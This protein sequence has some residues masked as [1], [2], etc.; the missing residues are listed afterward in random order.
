VLC[1]PGNGNICHREIECFGLG[2]PCICVTFKNTLYEPIIPDFHFI[3]VDIKDDEWFDYD[4]ISNKI[5][6]K[7][8]EVKDNKELLDYIK[9]N[10]MLYYN[11]YIRYPNN[12]QWTLRILG[13]DKEFYG[14]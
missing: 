3:H 11:T 9:N 7:Y 5:R 1:L 2:I 6:D 4:L 13:Y 10:A 14:K 8:Y 12:V